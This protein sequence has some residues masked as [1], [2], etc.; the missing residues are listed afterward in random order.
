MIA[1]TVPDELALYYNWP[2]GVR[3]S[4]VPPKSPADNAGIKVGDIVVAIGSAAERPAT[5]DASQETRLS[6]TGDFNDQL[7]LRQAD[8]SLWVRFI[9]P[10]DAFQMDLASGKLPLFPAGV[11]TQLAFLR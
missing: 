4:S 2:V 3:I 11:A 1:N 6:V 5:P 9:R 8:A 10:P 7:G